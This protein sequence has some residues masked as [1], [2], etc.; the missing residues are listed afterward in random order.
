MERDHHKFFQRD[1]YEEYK[2]KDREGAAAEKAKII[3]T[4]SPRMPDSQSSSFKR[5]CTK[6]R[7][8]KKADNALPQNPNK[9]KEIISSLAVKFQLRIAQVQKIYPGP[10]CKELTEVKIRWLVAALNLQDISYVS[11][12]KNDNVY[13]SKLDGEEQ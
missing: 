3:L 4:D 6:I 13:I 11:H 5:N 2:V 10:K 7:S 1:K 8:L 12:G 9:K